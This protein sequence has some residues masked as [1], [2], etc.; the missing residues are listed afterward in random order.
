MKVYLKSP[1]SKPLPE[2]DIYSVGLA[3]VS[4]PAGNPVSGHSLATLKVLA[5]D[6]NGDGMT[7]TFDLL[8]IHAHNGQTVDTNTARYD[9]NGDGIINVFD[10]LASRAHGGHVLP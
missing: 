1:I 10:M 7:N 9:I 3:G 8:N 2:V 4:D 5:G 6:A